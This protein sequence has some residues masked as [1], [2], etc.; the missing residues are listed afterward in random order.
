MPAPK[1]AKKNGRPAGPSRSTLLLSADCIINERWSVAAMNSVHELVLDATTDCAIARMLETSKIFNHGW[2]KIGYKQ[3]NQGRLY[4]MES[5]LQT[6]KGWIC[7]IVCQGIY[8]DLDMVNAA[9]TCLAHI[10]KRHIDYAPPTLTWYINDREA[11]FEKLKEKYV[12]LANVDKKSMKTLVLRSVHGGNHKRQL[13]SLGLPSSL[14][15]SEL[16]DLEGEMRECNDKLKN[17][18]VYAAMW[19]DI[20]QDDSKTNKHGSFTSMVWQQ[21]EAEILIVFKA[22][23]EGVDF[24][25]CVLK[26]DGL[27]VA[28]AGYS[29]FPLDIL[30]Q[31]EQHIYNVIGIQMKFTQKCMEPTQDDWDLF[32]GERH[33]ERI[34]SPMRKI[35]YLLC[36]YAKENDLKR[37]G[38]VVMLPHVTIPGVYIQGEDAQDYINKVCVAVGFEIPAMKPV[39]EWFEQCDHKCFPLIKSNSFN[40]KVISFANGYLN[41]DSLLFTLWTEAE[42]IPLT[43]HYFEKDFDPTKKETPLWDTI[44]NTQL[45]RQSVGA[46]EMMIGRLFYPIKEKDNWQVVP[47]IYGDANTGK[48]SIADVICKMFPDHHVG[49]ITASLEDRFGLYP[50]MNKRVVIAPDIPVDIHKRLNSADF[51]SM[52]TGDLMS[53]AIKNQA[54][55]SIRWE[56]NLIMFGNLIPR[57]PDNKGSVVRRIVPFECVTLVK[58][59]VSN[60][61]E[62]IVAN[63][64][65]QLILRCLTRYIRFVRDSANMGIWDCLDEEVVTASDKVRDATN[66]LSEFLANGNK[67]YQV[68]FDDG[69]ETPLDDLKTA[70]N[71]YMRF[72]KNKKKFSMGNDLHAVKHAGFKVVRRY[73]CKKCNMRAIKS[74]CGDHYSSDRKNWYKSRIVLNM[75]M[76]YK[77][78]RQQDAVFHVQ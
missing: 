32:Y 41:L 51:Q 1:R 43:D 30:R 3:K 63:E 17:V 10:L 64:L 62:R 75:R 27:Y 18:P 46:L 77:K 20:Q 5:S 65:P 35:T 54:S 24:K 7:R 9:P 52:V 12:D 4:S 50:L 47:V 68:V 25:V 78:D 31:A 55:R 19:R 48:S 28:R 59:R 67:Y 33:L 69:A 22:F 29:S 61:V 56:A 73:M 14:E 11:V 60:L 74:V 44:L 37:Y 70:F 13:A 58:E 2:L 6:L 40:R 23:L 72:D 26:H 66:P 42:E 45:G 36:K 53:M 71:N 49:A 76:I 15:I 16:S 57:W 34:R 38:S 39:K 21:L 8:F